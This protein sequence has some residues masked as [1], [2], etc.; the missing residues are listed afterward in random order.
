MDKDVKVRVS[1][2]HQSGLNEAEFQT[3]RKQLIALPHAVSLKNCSKKI[4]FYGTTHCT[5]L[6]Y[7][8]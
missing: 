7:H 8:Q 1:L 2:L 3:K 4:V 5:F 6:S